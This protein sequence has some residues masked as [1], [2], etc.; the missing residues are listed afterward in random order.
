MWVVGDAIAGVQVFRIIQSQSRFS[1]DPSLFVLGACIVAL[2]A[3]AVL[4]LRI[5]KT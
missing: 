1:G 3:A 2:P 4:M 5:E